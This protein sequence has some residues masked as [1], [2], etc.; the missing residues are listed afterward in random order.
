MG[1]KIDKNKIRIFEDMQKETRRYD[2]SYHHS[3]VLKKQLFFSA[4]GFCIK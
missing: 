2:P 1:N 4:K 3:N